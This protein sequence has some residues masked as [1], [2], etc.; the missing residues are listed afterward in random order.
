MS[1]QY[2]CVSCNEGF[3][4]KNLVVI[5]ELKNV[6]GNIF[7]KLYRCKSCEEIRISKQKIDKEEYER[8]NKEDHENYIKM[9]HSSFYE[10]NIIGSKIVDVL[11]NERGDLDIILDNGKKIHFD[12]D[13]FDIGF[14]DDT[15]LKIEDI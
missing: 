3:D 12:Y 13:D 8:K 4:L 15:S 7:G 5:H 11:F 1:E 2:L 10:D 14:S 6:Y 9:S